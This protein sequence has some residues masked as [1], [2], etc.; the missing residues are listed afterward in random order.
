MGDGEQC[1]I[2]EL[3]KEIGNHPNKQ[4]IIAEYQLHIYEILKENDCA[5]CDTYSIL[6]NRLG[7]PHE[8]AKM[9]KQENN[10]TPKK[11]QWLFV[12]CNVL[13][14]VGGALLTFLYNVFEWYWLKQLWLTLTEASFII[15]FIYTL[16]WG[17][18]GYEIGK[19]F[20]HRGYR[21]L[22]KTFIISII[23]N[24]LLMYLVVFKILPYDWFHPLLNFPFIL[25][26]LIF[27]GFLY[28]VSL[29]GYRWGRK[30]SV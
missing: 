12:L 1:F 8:I 10:M 11:T 30:V 22:K 25:T 4:D 9:W 26:C 19:E 7:T 2:K 5:E 29:I 14:F 20:G 28:P 3:Q 18:I 21:L 16:F 6:I 27:T 23:P 15:M 17:L 13:I 24:L